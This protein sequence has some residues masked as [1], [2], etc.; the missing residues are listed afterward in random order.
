MPVGGCK[1]V[2][3][4]GRFCER[5][6]PR[7]RSRQVLEARTRSNFLE[8]STRIDVWAATGRAYVASTE[9]CVA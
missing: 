6:V 9:F 1:R 7:T 8:L 2:G 3:A 5:R 4:C